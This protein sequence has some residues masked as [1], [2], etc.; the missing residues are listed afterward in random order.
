MNIDDPQNSRDLGKLMNTL[1]LSIDEQHE[2]VQKAGEA[3][4]FI[5]FVKDLNKGK[6]SF[7]K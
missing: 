2:F 3:K 7:S 4:D 6:I 5:S 1:N